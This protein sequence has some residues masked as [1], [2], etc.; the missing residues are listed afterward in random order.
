MSAFLDAAAFLTRVPVGRR[1]DG[2]PPSAAVRWFPVVGALVGLL[3]AAVYWGGEWL[4]G[5]FVGAAV[6]VAVQVLVTGAF[7]EDGLADTADAAGGWSRDERFRILDDPRHGTYGVLALVLAVIVRVAAVAALA[8][9]HAWVVLPAVH[10][11]S[12]GAAVALMGLIPPASEHGLGA[13]SVRARDGRDAAAGVAFALIAGAVLLGTWVLPAIA[14]VAVVGLA[15]AAY[16]RRTLGGI[17]GDLLGATQQLA[18]L[19]ALVLLA[20]AVHHGASFPWWP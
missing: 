18:D 9:E 14:V 12:R 4:A 8:P 3:T 10:A 15:M 7:H 5:P 19:A 11:L 2:P 1:P 20:G 17:A 6:A 13:S 16:A